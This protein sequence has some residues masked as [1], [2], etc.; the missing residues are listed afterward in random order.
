MPYLP[1][2]INT[3]KKAVLLVGA[4]NI[5]LAKLKLI[6][7]FSNDITIVARNFN[8]SLL[9]FA[10]NYPIKLIKSNFKKSHLN[11][12]QIIV[13]ATNDKELNKEISLLSHK[14]G[15]L[16]NVVDDADLSNFI[17]GA[18]VK[19]GDI[20]IAI[21][22]NG[23]SP[24]L[25]R[26]IKQRIEEILPL[27]FAKLAKFFAKHRKLIKDK[28][29]NL[30]AR[31]LF[32]TNIIE[33]NVAEELLTG[34][35]KTAEKLFL[36]ILS[37]Q[38]NMAKAAV[39][40]IGSG[41]GDPELI[42]L[43]AKR[44]IS[45]ADV[46]LHDRLVSQEIFNFARKDIIK[47]NV[48]KKRNFHRYTQDEIN[49]LIREYALAG[50]III[51]LKGGDATI[52]ARLDEEINAIKDLNIPYQVVPG[53]TA[54]SGAAASLGVSLT[55]RNLVRSVRFL[56]LYKKDLINKEYWQI[57]AKSNDSLVFYMSSNNIFEICQQLALHGKP[58]DTPVLLI[59]QATT[60]LQKEYGATLGN[61]YQTYQG[62]E[63][64]SPSL[65]IIGDIL[66][67]YKKYAWQEEKKLIGK[68]FPDLMVRNHV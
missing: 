68:Y 14:K 49:N 35:E 66:T 42:T 47:I 50:K 38:D 64:E 21:S 61:Y 31:R 57:L 48:G 24:V 67:E 41:P 1:L 30:Q 22:S 51:R 52:F 58:L 36:N 6:T 63:F 11:N 55:K 12:H 65:V 46:I 54:A 5:A 2:F 37:S 43:K 13:A 27:N 7:D 8:G 19:R 17:F 25:T 56:T 33:G 39:Y 20:N 9:E 34:N 18:V 28:L 60:P 53:I 40:F 10:Q 3:S 4:G 44:L 29:T 26:Y 15:L 59:E 16:V 23:S 45:K 62:Y 32:V